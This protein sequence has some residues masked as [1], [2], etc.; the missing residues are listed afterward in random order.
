MAWQ[1]PHSICYMTLADAFLTR[2]RQEA[3]SRSKSR[4]VKEGVTV[5]VVAVEGCRR[6]FVQGY[7]SRVYEQGQ[8]TFSKAKTFAKQTIY[9]CERSNHCKGSSSGDPTKT[10]ANGCSAYIS[11][12]FEEGATVTACVVRRRLT[13]TGHDP[14]NREESRISRIDLKLRFLIETWL[15]A[16]LK[17][18]EVMAEVARWN[19]THG[20][21]DHH[22]RRYFPTR[23]DIQQ[24]ALTLRRPSKPPQGHP[25]RRKPRKYDTLGKDNAVQVLRTEFREWCVF[26]QSRTTA[27]PSPRP[28]V[29]VLQNAAMREAM[30]Q[31]GGDLMCIRNNFEGLRQY[32]SAVYVVAVSDSDGNAHPASFIVTSDDEPATFL[33]A[34]RELLTHCPATPRVVML[35]REI[36]VFAEVL[37]TLLPDT[38]FLLPWVQVAQEVHQWLQASQAAGKENAGVRRMLLQCLQELRAC[39]TKE[40]FVEVVGQLEGRAGLEGFRAMLWTEWLAHPTRWSDFGRAALC[41]GPAQGCCVGEVRLF[42]LRLQHQFL[43]GVHT[44]RTLPDLLKL[45]TETVT[46]RK[47]AGDALLDVSLLLEGSAV[48]RAAALIK[49]GWPQLVTWQ[50]PWVAHVPCHTLLETSYRVNLLTLE[51]ECP[52]LTFG[53]P[54]VHLCLVSSLAQ[55]RQGASPQQ[56]RQQLAQ[57]ALEQGDYLLEA[58][59]CMTFHSSGVCVTELASGTC[60]CVAAALDTACVGALLVDLAREA[61]HTQALPP[62]PLA[63]PLAIKAEEDLAASQSP[64]IIQT[65]TGLPHSLTNTPQDLQE[66]QDLDQ[67]HSLSSKALLEKL[68]LWSTT[69]DFT[70]SEI[71][72]RLLQATHDA[73]W[74]SQPPPHPS[75][76]APQPRL[77]ASCGSDRLRAVVRTVRRKKRRWVRLGLLSPR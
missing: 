47:N 62:V 58:D 5:E 30:V 32:G 37:A 44:R 23:Q 59:C 41:G 66:A 26:Q 18:S 40:A 57:A 22:N 75:P 12:M 68:Y 50:G 17:V 19:K 39:D 71:L 9:E 2:L 70:D 63:A 52:L 49:Q 8:G 55:V 27:G 20:Y 61:G 21:T 72:H 46:H 53:G 76:A 74:G 14:N 16:G 35:D 69:K 48:E 65:H 51:C 25:P 34:F 42:F 77:A 54:C 24:M 29:V 6:G 31:Y 11:F 7:L 1:R 13:H 60:T 3:E 56:E 64:V 36:Q 15:G 38:L 4:M 10:R 33:L 28:L 43:K 45:L 73:V 67:A